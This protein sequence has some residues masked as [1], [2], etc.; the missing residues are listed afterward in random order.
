MK[1]NKVL[2][3]NEVIRLDVKEEQNNKI[4][5]DMLASV[6]GGYIES[7]GWAAGWE[8]TCPNCGASSYGMFDIWNES[9]IDCISGYKCRLC[10]K[11]FG[12]DQMGRIW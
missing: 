10:G 11:E 1:H 6:T 9:D 7:D 3:D 2:S 8:I 5:D 4:S 12:I